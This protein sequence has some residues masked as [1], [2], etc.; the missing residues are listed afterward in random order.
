MARRRGRGVQQAQARA[1]AEAA[2]LQR[3]GRRWFI[4]AVLAAV[5]AAAI[6]PLTWVVA[7]VLAGVAVWCVVRGVG[8]AVDAQRL[9]EP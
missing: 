9:L 1:Q 7:V 6:S 5:A 2:E 4:R 3:E 8:R